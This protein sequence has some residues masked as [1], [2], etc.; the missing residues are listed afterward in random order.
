MDATALLKEYRNWQR[1]SRQESLDREHR[2]AVRKLAQSGAMASR[3]AE[4]YRSMASRGA[5]EG[6]CYR[7]LFKR[8]MDD[9]TELACEG[10]LFVRRVLSEGGTTR[11]RATLLESFTLPSGTV[12]PG[13]LEP[14]GITLE[15]YDELLVSQSMQVGCRV[16]RRDDENDTRFLTFVDSVRGDLKAHL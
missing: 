16:D 6:A 2:A 1:F 11:V 5:S 4:S 15:I 3:M 14:Q 8:R 12:T 7:T 9:E 13:T 10:W